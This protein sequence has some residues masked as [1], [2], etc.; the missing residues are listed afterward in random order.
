MLLVPFMNIVKKVN[1]I[2]FQKNNSQ[3]HILLRKFLTEI[4]YSFL[5]FIYKGHI[6]FLIVIAKDS[7]K[8]KDI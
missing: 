6:L 5:Y 3:F 8:Q 4:P 1:Y 2:K 7:S